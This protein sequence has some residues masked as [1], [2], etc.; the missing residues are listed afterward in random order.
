MQNP[1]NFG[2]AAPASGSVNQT[3]PIYRGL[4]HLVSVACIYPANRHYRFDNRFMGMKNVN[5]DPSQYGGK[6]LAL[7]GMFSA[8]C[9]C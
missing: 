3:L 4:R 9:F 7:V 5:N 8:G 6:T 2:N 1:Q